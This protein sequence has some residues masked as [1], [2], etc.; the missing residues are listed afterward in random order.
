MAAAA[1]PGADTAQRDGTPDA[2]AA[3][4]HLE[5][6]AQ[7]LAFGT[8][9][10]APICHHVIQAATDQTERYGPQRDVVDDAAFTAA[11]LP[12][13]VTDDQRG[14]DAEDDAQR[15]RADGYRAEMPYAL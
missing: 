2:E 9:V 14:D 12:T 11:R 5:R 1:D 8:E 10:G 4:P 13:T 3:F 15:V 6:G 7:P